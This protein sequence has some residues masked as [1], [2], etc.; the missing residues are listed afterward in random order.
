VNAFTEVLFPMASASPVRVRSIY[1]RMLLASVVMASLA[2]GAV[3]LLRGPLM[4]VMVLGRTG[5]DARPLIPALA[6]G[7]FLVALSPAPFHLLNG[8]GKPWVNS[9]FYASML[10]STSA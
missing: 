10:C 2:F 1:H 5:N 7:W 3:L 6:L 4:S 9:V 8:L